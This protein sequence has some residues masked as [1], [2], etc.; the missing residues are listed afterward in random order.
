MAFEFQLPDI[1]EGVHEGEIVNWIVDE[2]DAVAED[3]PIVEVMTDKATVEITSPREGTIQTLHFEEGDVVEVGQVL[4]TIEEEGDAAAEPEP[5]P[6]TDEAAGEE[7]E[8][9]M[10]FQPPDQGGDQ[11]RREPRAQTTDGGGAAQQQVATPE[12]RTLATPATRKLARELD[13]DIDQVPGSGEKGRVLK[14]DVRRFAEEGPP[15]PEPEAAA[16]TA[17]A[18]RKEAP[19][20][21]PLQQDEPVPL[22]GLRGQIH[23]NMRR[24]KDYAAHFTYWEEIDVTELVELRED[25]KDVAEDRGVNLTYLPFLVKASVAALKEFP[26]LNAQIDEESD[27]LVRKS[28]YNIGVAVA[29]DRGLMVVNVRDADEK[30]IFEIAEDI[31]ELATK[32]REGTASPEELQ[33]T[34]FTITSLGA[35]GGLGATPVINHPESA[36][37]GVHKIREVPRFDDGEVV[38]RKIMNLSWSFDH[39]WIDGHVGAEFAQKI[40]ELL[41]SPNLLLLGTG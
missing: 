31:E 23:E 34:T 13:V 1:G 12:G 19:D 39:R 41:E 10:L 32:A 15:T 7:D 21:E 26:D 2:G 11:K 3:E 18:A 6:E 33:D 24:S 38:P 16:P 5:E 35:Q 25:A 30:S 28:D 17:E 20:V 37:M 22:E 29:T 14:E 9:E 4:V 27:T 8:D 40:R 36:I